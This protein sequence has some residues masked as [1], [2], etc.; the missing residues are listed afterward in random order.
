VFKT[1]LS[2][3]KR[4]PLFICILLLIVIVTFSAVAYIGFRNASIEIGSERL[5][6]LVDK[7]SLL[8]K[9]SLSKSAL[10]TEAVAKQDSIK[11]YLATP[12]NASRFEALEAM[13]KLFKKDTL[14]KAIQLLNAQ[15]K[16]VLNTGKN[17]LAANAD[18][19]AA[20]QFPA[21]AA[22]IGNIITVK[23]AMYY[24][25]IAP[26]A[27]N[28]KIMGYLINWRLLKATQKSL[29][30][31]SQILGSNGKLYFGNDDG[32]FWTN[33]VKPVEKPPVPLSSL[34]TVAQYSRQ[35]GDLLIGSMRKIPNTSWVVLVELSSSFF[36]KT[37][38]LFLRWVTIIG[39]LLIIGGSV[40]GWM[41]SRN[42]TRP[43]KELSKA[44][45]AIAEGDYYSLV[46][47]NRQDELGTLAE[48][49]NIMAVRVHDAQLQ[50]EQ[51]V[52]ERTQELQTAI[53]NIQNQKENEKKKDEFIS[54]A[55]HELKTPLTTIKAFF[56]L[57]KREIHPDFKSYNFISKAAGQLNRM[58]NLIED[59]LDVSKINSGKMQYNLE[60]FD[61]HTALTEAIEGVQEISPNHKLILEQSASVTFHGDRHRMEQV[62]INLLSNAVKYSPGADKVLIKSE[63]HDD[64]LVVT[65]G[66]FGI[67]IEKEHLNKLFER[68][69]RIEHQHRFN[70]LG[71][72]LFISFE[73]IKRHNGSIQVQSEPGK[74]SAFIIKLP[75]RV[76]RAVPLRVDA[77][78]APQPAL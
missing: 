27:D 6:T 35:N 30:Q 14:C 64:Q 24:P 26:I 29:D 55:S 38:Y 47:L 56:Q 15:Q 49:F 23:G 11:H 3:E 9:E 10:P 61:F 68:Y 50:L 70:G 69:Y 62:I 59:L 39:I 12:T 32:R 52:E 37:A 75:V 46:H 53:V 54:I 1:Q 36:L 40:G 43:L 57:A 51:K 13:Q 21:V 8:F 5:T 4:L 45:S 65:V 77:P 2:I 33:L 71:L 74:G 63:L 20:G 67:G 73:I 31:F 7:L 44:A 42:I 48:S 76:Q 17:Y 16:D 58:E 28:N 72:G 25:V 60:D 34:H 19:N 18:V 41:M 78:L 22:K 66:D